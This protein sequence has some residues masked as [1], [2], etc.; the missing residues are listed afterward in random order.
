MYA[1]TVR[2]LA[3]ALAFLFLA[4]T[5]CGTSTPSKFYMLNAVANPVKKSS[6]TEPE[7]QVYIGVGPVEFPAYLDRHQIVTRVDENQVNL[8]MF[9]EW[10]EP[11]KDNFIRV[12]V[13]NLSALD[14]RG[15][16]V[17]YPMRGPASVDIQLEMEVVRLDGKL[18]GDVSLVARWAIFRKNRG[19]MPMT[20]KTEITEPTGS[21]DYRSLVAAQSRAVEAL[22]R[23][24]S[25]HI[26]RFSKK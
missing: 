19:E 17:V 5:G 11:L 13:E 7:R 18:G 23:E 25:A 26:S 4:L 3:T 14:T 20:G 15:L 24:I 9:H 1:K 8:A 10:A 21:P 16:F 2:Y 22:S 12:F 6:Q